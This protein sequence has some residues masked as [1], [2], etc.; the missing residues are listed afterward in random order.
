M[1]WGIVINYRSD[2]AAATE[3]ASQIK[4]AGGRAVAIKANVG[5]AAEF[6]SLFDQGEDTFGKIDTL[7]NNAGIIRQSFV[8]DLSDAAIDE[9]IDID[10]RGTIYG[11][12]EAARRLADGGHIINF[13]STTLALNHPAMASTMRQRR[14]SKR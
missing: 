6:T 10:L 5:V 14:P 13:S 9:Q 2:E 3:V 7:I 4:R 1:G 11:M 12:R 8:E